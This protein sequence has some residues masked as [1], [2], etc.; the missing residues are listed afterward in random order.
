MPD[1][2]NT[3][4]ARFFGNVDRLQR[5]EMREIIIFKLSQYN[6]PSGRRVEPVTPKRKAECDDEKHYLDV[7]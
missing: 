7:R 3:N 5:T 2:A 6:E 4:V 1:Q